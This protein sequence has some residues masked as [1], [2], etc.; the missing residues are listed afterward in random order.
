MLWSSWDWG[1]FKQVPLPLNDFFSHGPS[2]W[3]S[4]TCVQGNTC[5]RPR[6]IPWTTPSLPGIKTRT[7]RRQTVVY[8]HSPSELSWLTQELNSFCD[9]LFS[10]SPAA[11]DG[12]T[13][14]TFAAAK[15]AAVEPCLRGQSLSWPGWK[16]SVGAWSSAWRYVK[17]D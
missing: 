9:D 3:A 5:D 6:I 17:L 16:R 11:H 12:T 10:L 2:L 7:W 15:L 1:I 13:C 8:I 4:L 14:F